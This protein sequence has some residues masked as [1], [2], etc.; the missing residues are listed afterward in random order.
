MSSNV[1]AEPSW[2]KKL[3]AELGPSRLV[4]SF[5]ARN[6]VT[7]YTAIC[8]FVLEVRGRFIFVDITV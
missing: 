3:Q 1:E 8:S 7:E 4:I 2:A 6:A 5:R